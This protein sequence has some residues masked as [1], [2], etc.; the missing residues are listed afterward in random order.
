MVMKHRLGGG[1]VLIPGHIDVLMHTADG[2]EQKKFG[3]Q[4]V[5]RTRPRHT[6]G[7][8]LFVARYAVLPTRGSELVVT[9]HTGS[10]PISH[11]GSASSSEPFSVVSRGGRESRYGYDYP[12]LTD[13]IV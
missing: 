13:T 7:K 1:I 11:I 6:S 12:D 2:R 3:V 8:A 10:H 9:Y 4:L 5:P